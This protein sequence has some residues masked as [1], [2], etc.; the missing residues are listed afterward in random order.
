MDP[1][2]AQRHGQYTFTDMTSNQAIV[3]NQATHPE[4]KSLVL[5]AIEYVHNIH[6]IPAASA[7]DTG[8]RLREVLNVVAV[9]MA[10][11]VYPHLKGKI[12]V[13]TS[14]SVSY[15][16][17]ETIAA[18][19]RRI[20]DLFEAHGIPSAQV[21]VKIP[22]TS[23]GIAACYALSSPDS[24][25]GFAPINTLVRLLSSPLLMPVLRLKQG[26]PMSPLTSM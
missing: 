14:P 1:A 13:Q 11:L 4:N 16:A 3:Y 26:A 2:V 19:A 9:R 6:T 15:D 12:L 25:S 8:A 10:H 22:A 21:C 24:D 18:H 20:V 5:E 23:A 7:S 17:E